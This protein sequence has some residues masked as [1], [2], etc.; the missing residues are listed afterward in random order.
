MKPIDT[1][2]SEVWEKILQQADGV[3]ATWVSSCPYP[4]AET[5]TLV[6]TGA[7]ILG[8]T[9]AQALEAYGVYFVDYVTQQGYT[10]LLQS[11]G[12][13]IADFL[14]NL[15]NLHLHLSM[16]FP[17]MAPPGFKVGAVTPTSLEL[18]YYSARPALGP[19][20]V[21]VLKQLGKTYWGFEVGVELLRGRDDC[22][23]DHEV[24]KV[25][26][27]RQEALS[28]WDPSSGGAAP[29]SFTLAP[30]DF[31]QLFP[32]HLLLD[33]EL[34]VVQCGAVLARL[35]PELAQPGA[36]LHDHFSLRHPYVSMTYGTIAAELNSVFLLKSLANGMELKGQMVLTSAAGATAKDAPAFHARPISGGK[37]PFA[38]L[39]ALEADAGVPAAAAAAGGPDPHTQRS[40]L[41]LGSPRVANLDD[42]RALRLFLSDIPLHDLSRDFV[43]LAEQRQAE[44]DLKER[45]EQLSMQLK[46]ANERLGEL[47]EWLHDERQRSDALL[48]QMLPPNVAQ[49]LKQGDRAP[50]NEH[51]EATILFS[52]ICGFTE[53]SSQASPM[54]VCNMLDEL[55]HQFD[56]LLE[57]SFP[58]LYKV[59]T[60]GDAYMLV[61][62]VTT[63]CERHADLVLEFAIGMH[64]AAKRVIGPTGQPLQIRVGVHTGAVVSGVV[65]K[66]MPRFCLFGDA[67]NT[68]SR[69]ESHGLPGQIH[70]SAAAY[71]C[72]KDKARFAIR[73]RGTVAVKG[74][75]NM[76]T[77]LICPTEDEAS[78]DLLSRGSSST[79]FHS[80]Q[81][82]GE[83]FLMKPGRSTSNS[84][85]PEGV[86]P[87]QSVP[88][89]ARCSSPAAG[90]HGSH[91]ASLQPLTMPS[92]SH[93]TPTAAAL[94][95]SAVLGSSR[96]FVLPGSGISSGD[97]AG[98]L[99]ASASQPLPASPLRKS[100]TT[101]GAFEAELLAEMDM[102]HAGRQRQRAPPVW[103]EG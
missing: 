71:A 32:F 70:I 74:K 43:L 52:D 37:C 50:A 83:S 96:S 33:E 6:L 10:K 11:L 77:Y 12:S 65:G 19:I 66:K 22:S 30:D 63:P 79:T 26:Y 90:S 24:F 34:R 21:G 23:D 51:P 2:G 15:N 35:L 62:N 81:L 61:G 73:E 67:V 85:G 60:I 64:R 57:T 40:L 38:G 55:Y 20:V 103:P 5:Y 7:K 16:G 4:D 68:A 89:F 101:R 45:F 3:K 93:R 76:M 14:S 41:F 27:P 72:I 29:R 86:H 59:E 1:F 84:S 82:H 53:I 88:G 9:P 94:S 97:A 91:T 42:M 99:A 28:Q 102:H 39:S 95:P 44:A 8:V 36:T 17:A 92:P 47:T 49:T 87:L 56:T 18:H 48:Y 58:N 46:H 80:K 13:T 69:M 100:S 98:A 78:L 25:T 31:Y 75:G 54:D